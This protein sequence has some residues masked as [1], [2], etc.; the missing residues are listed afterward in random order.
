MTIWALTSLHGAPGVTTLGLALATAWPRVNHRPVLLVEADPTGGVLAARF[1]GHMRL[2]RSLASLAVALR[3]GWDH[4]AALECARELTPGVPVVVAPPAGEQVRSALAAGGD[5]LAAALAS[6]DVD[7]IVDAG[8][9]GPDPAT[10]DLLRRATVAVV[11]TRARLEDAALLRSRAGP[12]AAAGVEAGL[13]VSG[14]DPYEPGE[15]A[16]AVR[17]PLLGTLPHDP[18]AV[19]LLGEGDGSPRRLRRS[20]WWRATVDLASRLAD[21]RPAL[22]DLHADDPSPPV[23]QPRPAAADLVAQENLP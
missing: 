8:R 13:V 21:L 19:S 22:P 10:L 12:L 14:H 4:V 5:R 7:V 1:D 18:G 20:P 9:L 23:A 3:H 17:L 6:G 16:E 2:D 11:V 15:L